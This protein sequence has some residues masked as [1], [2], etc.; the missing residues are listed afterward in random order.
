MLGKVLHLSH[1]PAQVAGIIVVTCHE[2]IRQHRLETV[3]LEKEVT[4]LFS[5]QEH[6]H[7]QCRLDE[8]VHP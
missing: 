7:Q 2:E 1:I 6:E 4:V 8:A 3:L 5:A